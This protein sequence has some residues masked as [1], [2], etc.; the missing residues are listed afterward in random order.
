MKDINRKQQKDIT[1]L[2]KFVE[3]FCHGKH[4]NQQE[5]VFCLPD[6]LDSVK[7][8]N[9]CGD[10]LKYAIAKRLKC[11]LEANKPTCKHCKIHCYAKEQREK[12][13]EIMSYA[14]RRIM[15][16]GRIDYLWH[17]FF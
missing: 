2:A 4:P 11:P 9:D 1:L 15:L 14:G 17:Y 16:K 3:I 13:R 8:C 12:V 6:E 10:F 5:N 7:L